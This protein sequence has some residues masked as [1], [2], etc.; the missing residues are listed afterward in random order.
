MTR[1]ELELPTDIR[2]FTSV[3]YMILRREFSGPNGCSRLIESDIGM[4]ITIYGALNHPFKIF[5]S[6]HTVSSVRTGY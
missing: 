3:F 4:R 5:L 6:S 2:D 1:V